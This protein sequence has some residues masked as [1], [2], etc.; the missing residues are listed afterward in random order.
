M[1]SIALTNLRA[2]RLD[3]KTR[4]LQV[5]IPTCIVKSRPIRVVPRPHQLRA[6][7]LDEKTRHLTVYPG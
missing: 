1:A 2:A 6:A 5:P 7:R 4:Q 3:E